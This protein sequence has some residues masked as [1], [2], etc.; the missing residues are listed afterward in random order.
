MILRLKDVNGIGDLFKFLCD[1]F[2]YGY[3][4]NGV[5]YTGKRLDEDEYEH[6]KTLSID[7]FMKHKVGTC[8]DFAR[9]E[10]V[11]ILENIYGENDEPI[12]DIK[13]WYIENVKGPYRPCHTW[14]SYKRHST[15][16]AFEV[17]WFKHR[18]IHTYKNESEMLKDYANKHCKSKDYVIIEVDPMGLANNKLDGLTPPEFMDFIWHNGRV[19]RKSGDINRPDLLQEMGERLVHNYVK[20]LRY[21]KENSESI[22]DFDQAIITLANNDY[23]ESIIAIFSE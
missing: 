15:V 5:K 4:S 14:I 17:S 6:Y 7:N 13:F 19:V 23:Y 8:F 1:E 22:T 10:Y 12:T 16:E 9:F 11:Y 20:N 18:G 21:L 3:Y 2:D